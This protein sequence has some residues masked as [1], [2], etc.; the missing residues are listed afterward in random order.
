MNYSYKFFCNV[1]ILISLTMISS[2]AES[3][4]NR[5]FD[6]CAIGAVAYIYSTNEEPAWACGKLEFKNLL[7]KYS[8]DGQLMEKYEN[9]SDANPN[10]VC[11]VPKSGIK[12]IVLS[13]PYLGSTTNLGIKVSPASEKGISFDVDINYLDKSK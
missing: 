3:K 6:S 12:V 13:K 4:D 2:V 7:G 10:R 11:F 1:S 9:N 5:C 8:V